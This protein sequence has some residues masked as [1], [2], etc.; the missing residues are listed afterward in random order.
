MLTRSV[1]SF[2]KSLNYEGISLTAD[3]VLNFK[4]KMQ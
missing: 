1:L 3:D 2:D 4:K